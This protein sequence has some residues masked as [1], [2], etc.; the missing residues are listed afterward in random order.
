MKC[1]IAIAA[2]LA[3]TVSAA[4]ARADTVQDLR[5]ELDE[6]DAV[7]T[8]ASDGVLGQPRVRTNPGLIRMWFPNVANRPRIERQGDGSVFRWLK[9]RA[10]MNGSVL[11]QL[12]VGDNRRVA[13][14]DIRLERGPAGVLIRI[15]RD[16]LPTATSQP[17]L[18]APADAAPSALAAAPP[19]TAAPA[20]PPAAPLAAPAAPVA[21]A[22]P[23][24]VERDGE[25][26]VA[27]APAPAPAA[28]GLPAPS[29][30]GS[31]F[32]L[33]LLLTL[34]LGLAYGAIRYVGRKRGP[35]IA[36]PIHVIASRRLGPRHQ[37]VVVRALG[38]DHLL[39][40]NAGQTQRLAS[41]PSPLEAEA[42][43][44][45]PD[46]GGTQGGLLGKLGR[47]FGLRVEEDTRPHA[48][49][50]PEAAASAIDDSSVFGAQLMRAA[51]TTGPSARR[52]SEAVAGLI[53]LRERLGLED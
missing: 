21:A 24:S 31:S 9:A 25:A 6:Q 49:G 14:R 52:Q 3:V 30:S 2:V 29:A 44:E 39:S 13:V 28:A 53:A 43:A 17:V 51:A 35:A 33:M 36:P 45:G 26:E 20:A 50:G 46:A 37:I 48:M 1:A 8:V 42:P 12:R 47:G 16:R 41:M 18:P 34:I 4:T 38:E 22:D 27:P 19:A 10:G 23:A 7:I 5:L 40:I 15:A 11:V 32:G